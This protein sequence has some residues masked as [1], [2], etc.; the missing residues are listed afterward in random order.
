MLAIHTYTQRIPNV[1][2]PKVLA[3][4]EHGRLPPVPPGVA[5]HPPLWDLIT[6]CTAKNPALRPTAKLVAD[7]LNEMMQ[8]IPEVKW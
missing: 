5:V 3:A 2:F 8:S 1:L 4:L 7:E 6:R